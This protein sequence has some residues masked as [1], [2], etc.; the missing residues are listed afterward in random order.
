M[1]NDWS[2]AIRER[3][4]ALWEEDGR[5]DGRDVDHW[6]RAEEEIA[7]GALV[8]RDGER[9]KAAA[10]SAKSGAAKARRARAGR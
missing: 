3:A 5:I 10:S 6:L 4:Y 2:D 9:R 8:P 7:N 1:P